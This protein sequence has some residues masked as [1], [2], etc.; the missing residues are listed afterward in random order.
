[1]RT[2]MKTLT[3]TLA[4][5]LLGT[6]QAQVP[7]RTD[8]DSALEVAVT[9]KGASDKQ[10]NYVRYVA[11][12]TRKDDTARDLAVRFAYK[13][14]AQASTVSGFSGEGV[15]EG[16]GRKEVDVAAERRGGAV[17]PSIPRD[18]LLGYLSVS[19]AARP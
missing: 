2:A 7:R 14:P 15:V 8:C 4:V 18:Q 12:F 1:M 10:G 3:A 13:P 19:C 6:A 9:A 16:M 17:T 5:T 11:V